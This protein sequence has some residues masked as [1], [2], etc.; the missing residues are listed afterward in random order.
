MKKF[1]LLLVA[2]LGFWG[3]GFAQLPIDLGVKAG[4]NL[5]SLPGGSNSTT[6]A[7]FHGGVFAGVKFLGIGARAE[8]L[9]SGK[10]SETTLQYKDLSS[11][12]ATVYNVVSKVNLWYLDI[13]IM[14]D[15][16]LPVLPIHLRVGPQF[17]FLLNDK[18]EFQNPLNSSGNPVSINKDDFAFNKA[19]V[20]L[21]GDIGVNFLMLDAGVRYNLGLTSVS[22]FKNL[23]VSDVNLRNSVFQVYVGIKFL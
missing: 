17:S 8:L 4:L 20:G 15:Y 7:G 2:L 5:N 1:S 22:N 10:G 18:V 16:K 23:T 11:S 21:V 14:F 12:A 3:V 6:A 9:V 19:E 13:P